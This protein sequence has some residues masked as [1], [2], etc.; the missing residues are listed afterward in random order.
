MLF[1][2]VDFISD[3]IGTKFLVRLNHKLVSFETF[4][5]IFFFLMDTVSFK[6]QT[7]AFKPEVC[8]ISGNFQLQN[9]LN[10]V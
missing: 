2:S 5:G 7:F 10:A 9:G 6:F 8:E 3:L 4:S 1:H